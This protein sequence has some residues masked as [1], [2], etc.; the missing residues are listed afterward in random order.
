MRNIL[1]ALF[2]FI[3]NTSTAQNLVPNPSFEDTISCALST[4]P[5]A[6]ECA[7]PWYTSGGTPDY[8]S[9]TYSCAS[10]FP[11]LNPPFGFQYP[12]TGDAHIGIPIFTDSPLYPNHREYFGVELSDALIANHLY[13]VSFYVSL[14]N[15][16]RFATDDIGAFF[17]DTSTSNPNGPHLLIP[18]ITPQ[19][20]NQ[21]GNLLSDTMNWMLVSDTFIAQGGE[22]FMT[23]GNFLHDSI[24]TFSN[25]Y[26]NNPYLSIYF[27]VD[28]VSVED[29]TVG[30][31]DVQYNNF[32][33]I[34]PSP[35]TQYFTVKS[36]LRFTEVLITDVLGR[37]IYRKKNQLVSD[38]NI[39][40]C[41][42][43]HEGIYLLTVISGNEINNKK[44]VK[45]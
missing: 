28:D 42:N 1:A 9:I 4:N 34:Y 27:F 24:T 5:Y 7:T 25:A 26:P 41:S 33:A 39:I 22:K 19:I 36:S 15:Q 6:P 13:H 37:V 10:T 20:T 35:A 8:C 30:I 38:Y 18:K 23:I 16:C 21:P 43:W 12:R 2:I 14:A 31:E 45:N 44:V 29:I 17:S 11:P 3:S 40:E 32:I